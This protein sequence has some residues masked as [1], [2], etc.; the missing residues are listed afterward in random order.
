MSQQELD[1][2]LYFRD[3]ATTFFANGFGLSNSAQRLLECIL[4]LACIAQQIL[5]REACFSGLCP[6][7]IFLPS[8]TRRLEDRV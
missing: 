4:P 1:G 7:E 5:A 6:T 3:V 8:L 2:C